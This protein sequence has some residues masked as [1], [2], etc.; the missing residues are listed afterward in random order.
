[1][2]IEDGNLAAAL[3]LVESNSDFR[4]LR[5]LPHLTEQH[6][7]V[8]ENALI[9][10]I[11]DV[12]TTGLDFEIDEVIEL[13]MMK[14]SFSRSGEI[15]E[16]F[17]EYKSLNAPKSKIPPSVT[18][19]TGI[20]DADVSG[21]K[22]AT[23]DVDSFI[24]GSALVIAHNAAFDRPFC[25]G[26]SPKFAELSWACTATEVDWGSEGIAGSRLEYIANSFGRFYEAHRAIDDCNA[27]A[28][29]L[30]FR[31]PI[32]GELVL[33]AL[34][35]AARRTETRVFAEGA[36]YEVR[37]P[38]KRMGYRWNDGQNGFPRSWWKDVG[39]DDLDRELA[40]LASLDGGNIRPQLFRM[41][42]RNR[43]RRHH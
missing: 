37:I 15:G 8:S 24:A 41:T 11:V 32:S 13:G 25:E 30:T 31:L 34:L 14:F 3:A 39:S 43:F 16:F 4:V 17:A 18:K 5:R 6:S 40:E 29:V 42:A 27:V 9:G 10:V 26:L 22:I 36:P 35:R 38:L 1:M 12:E 2:A 33:D 20:G 19:L 7:N 23:D 21:C 28:N